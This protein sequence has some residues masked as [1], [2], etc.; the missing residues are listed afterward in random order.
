MCE[1]MGEEG[2]EACVGLYDGVCL[3]GSVCLRECV[4][5]ARRQT[6]SY[7]DKEKQFQRG[8]GSFS[9]GSGKEASAGH[10]SLWCIP[11]ETW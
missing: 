4:C 10:C 11:V 6:D 8:G 1:D 9:V 5:D 7:T 3:C 2:E